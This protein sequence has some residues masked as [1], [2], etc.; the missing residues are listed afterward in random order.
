M[1]NPTRLIA[2]LCTAAL[3]LTLFAGCSGASSSGGNIATVNGEAVTKSE[4]DTKLENGAGARQVL[5]TIVQGMLID[6]YAKDNNIQ[7]SEADINKKEDE[8]K[9]KYPAGQFDQ[10]LKAQNLTEKDV[11]DILRQQLVLEAAVSKQVHVSD[12]D[13]ADYLSKNHATLDKPEQVRAKHIL[14]ADKKTADTVEAQLKAGA[15]F[16]DLAKKYSTDPASKDKGG[17]LG[18]FQKGQMV[19]AF[20]EAAWKQPLN[21][22]GPPVKSP[23]GYHI[24]VVEERKPATVATMAN[25]RDQIL[26][27]LKQQQEQTQIPQF[28]QTLRAKAKIDVVDPRFQSAFPSPVPG[29]AGGPGGAPPG[30]RPAAPSS[31][32]AQAT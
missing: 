30:A 4:L 11:H 18:F 5:N 6:Q 15:K 20:Q 21:V 23:F 14:V 1:S 26:D 25:S 32:A 3:G 31:P 16:E 8:I 19:P 9:A 13:I 7:I 17:E 12:K 2:G 22:V 28:L 27:T 10:I 29:A 24:I